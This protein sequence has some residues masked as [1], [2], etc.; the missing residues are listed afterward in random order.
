MILTYTHRYSREGRKL[1]PRQYTRTVRLAEANP[2]RGHYHCSSCGQQI[3]N[4]QQRL[5][6]SECQTNICQSCAPSD[7]IRYPAN[8]TDEAS[9]ATD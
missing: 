3:R 2:W 6:D 7:P 8:T 4:G 1:L 9:S 5:V